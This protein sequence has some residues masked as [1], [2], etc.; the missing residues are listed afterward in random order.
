MKQ[1][2]Y[3]TILPVYSRETYS[4]IKNKKIFRYENVERIKKYCSM[5]KHYT[6][7]GR[8]E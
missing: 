8:S 2:L 4:N 7:M 5:T 1:Y 3:G 6:L